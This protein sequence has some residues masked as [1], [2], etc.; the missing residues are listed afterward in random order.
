[1]S[2]WDWSPEERAR[3]GAFLEQ[4]GITSGDIV[5]KAIGDGHS[6]LTFLVSDAEGSQVVVRRPPPPP[7][8]PGAHDML[9]EARL[10]GALGDT[11]VPVADLLATAEAGEVID[12]H[13]YVM[14]F[15]SG[16]VVTTSTPAPLD[17]S[18]TRRAIGEMLVDTLA[19]LHAVDWVAAGLSDIGRPEGFNTRHRARMARLVADADGNPPP[20]FA[21]VDAW[22]Q[23]NVPAESGATIVH[24]DFRIGNVV[25]SADRP[26][27]VEAVLDWEL[28]TLGDP[29]FDLGYFLASVPGL[30][31]YN[32]T[33]RFGLAMLEEG[34]PSRDELAARYAARTGADLRNLDWYTTL[35]LW[36]LAVLYEY[37]RRRAV[38][39]VGD[40]Y[41]ADQRLVQAFLDDAHR[42]AGL[43]PPPPAPQS[44]E[45]R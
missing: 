45:S 25:L 23:E 26:G 37:G 35:A 14:S 11:A 22:L 42:S 6:N 28:A 1:M 4:R 19:D 44:E 16:P 33:Q 15:A 32:P 9:R 7:T 27:G 20:H 18:T 34:Y 41:Y 31:P 13:F 12:V 39:G 17:A 30:A 43:P 10:I 5:T 21:V 40:P 29:L 36:K 24:N 8:P 2:D 3:L 38:R